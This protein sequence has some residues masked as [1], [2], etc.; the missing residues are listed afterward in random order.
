MAITDF[1]KR[2][3]PATPE[4][5]YTRG[6]YKKCR[7]CDAIL[8]HRRYV[9]KREK[10]PSKPTTEDRFWKK[11]SKGEGCWTWQ[12]AKS[13][14]YGKFGIKT[15]SGKWTMCWSHRFSYE[16]KHGTIGKGLHIDHLCRN[17][18]CVNPDHLEAVLQRTNLLRGTGFS[19]INFKKT[20]CKRGHEF[21]EENTY[22]TKNGGRNCRQCSLDSIK[23]W[24]AKKK[25]LHSKLTGSE[26]QEVQTP[27]Q[28]SDQAPHLP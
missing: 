26:S 16:L 2:G 13:F 6:S 23:I 4:N 18:A 24:R 9:K 3:H 21:T 12:G 8:A 27:L 11:V 1:C 25:H 15:T 10:L 22:K 20:H 14:G 5:I 17:R 28:P 7:L 19:A